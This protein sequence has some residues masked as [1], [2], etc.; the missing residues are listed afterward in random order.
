MNQSIK[1][2]DRRR[3]GISLVASIAAHALLVVIISVANTDKPLPNKKPPQIMD[4]VLLDSNKTKSVK[5]PEDA[6]TMSN[7]SAVGG[8]SKAQDKITRA[9]RAPAVGQQQKPQRP[10]PPAQPKNP[11]PSPAPQKRI[12]TLAKRGAQPDRSDRPKPPKKQSPKA[13]KTAPRIPLSNLMPSSM[14]LAQLSRDFQKEKRMKQMLSREADIPINTREAKYAPYAQALVR[15]LEEQW[16]PGQAN[17]E[18]FPDD[19]RR[20]LMRITIEHNG[21]LGGVEILRPSPIPQIN[22]SA[23]QAIH[24]AAPFRPLPSAWGLDRVSFYLTFEVVEDKFVFHAM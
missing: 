8:S 22:E 20:S 18:Q 4:V 24:L 2:I 14:A 6:K 19:A 16:R 1:S 9:A 11:P 12:R 7:L 5:P 13:V 3:I 15:A 21:E 17:Y 23:V 10:A